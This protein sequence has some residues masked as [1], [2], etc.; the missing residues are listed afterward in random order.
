MANAIKGFYQE[1]CSHG[2]TVTGDDDFYHNCPTLSNESKMIME[3]DITLD[4]LSDALRTCSDSAPGS[5]GIPY[6]VYKKLWVMAGPLMLGAWNHSCG[7]G[8]LP[9]SHR[10]SVIVLLPKEGESSERL[11]LG[12]LIEVYFLFQR[13]IFLI[14]DLL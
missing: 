5:D 9:V 10:E 1:L 2:D 12:V 14:F 6:S 13:I 3:T 4:E 11:F 7:I 8:V